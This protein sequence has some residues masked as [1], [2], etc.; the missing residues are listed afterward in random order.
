VKRN[1]KL[2]RFWHYR[3]TGNKHFSA[4]IKANTSDD[5]DDDDDGGGGIIN[6]Y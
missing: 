5:D 2:Y 6:K 1:S 3:G 4:R